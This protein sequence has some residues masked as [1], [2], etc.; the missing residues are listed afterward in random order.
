MSIKIERKGD[1]TIVETDYEGSQ[2]GH[3][4]IHGDRELIGAM[5]SFGID[6]VETYKSPLGELSAAHDEFDR[7]FK[8]KTGRKQGYFGF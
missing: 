3:S 2:V 8:E 4:M 1:R 6:K 5:K 7:K